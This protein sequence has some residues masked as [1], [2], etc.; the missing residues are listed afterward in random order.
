[1][2]KLKAVM[3]LLKS[4]KVK[5]RQEGL[6][7][8]KEAFSRDDAVLNI[9]EGRAWLVVYQALFTAVTSEKAEC[10]KKAASGKNASTGVAAL[11]RLGDATSAVRWLV[12]RSNCML[13][14]KVLTPLLAHLLQMMVYRGQLYTPLALNYL[15]TIKILL[16]WTPHMEHI[17]AATWINIAELAFNII[18]DDPI[19]GNFDDVTGESKDESMQA[20]VSAMYQ[21]DSDEDDDHE[22]SSSTQKRKRK[23][24]EHS[25]TPVPGTMHPTKSLKVSPRHSVSLEQV[26][27]AS[28]LALLFRSPT[29]PFLSEDVPNLSFAI[30]SR[31]TRFLERY[32]G[33]ASLH[34]DYLL[35]LQ[36]VLSHLC[37]NRT[38]DVENFAH[39]TWNQLVGLWGTKNKRM[40]E[41][42]VG[43]LRTLFPFLTIQHDIQKYTWADGVYKLWTL[44]SGEAESRRG[45]DSLSLDSLRFEIIPSATENYGRGVFVARTFRAG[46]HFDSSQALAW[47]MM[48]LQADCANKASL[49][50]KIGFMHTD[51]Y[52]T[53][54]R[55]LRVQLCSYFGR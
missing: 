35:A 8:L 29:A 37:L 14:T 41:S 11:R 5:E 30:L 23:A 12:E 13:T 3:E 39:S 4:S 2:T 36:P 33:D 51:Y 42:L 20:D 50:P 32:S 47:A 25:S 9:N 10:I 24:R 6:I 53:A 26:E 18:L 40:K 43:I 28:L 16:G 45:L 22:P 49:H 7:S 54:R 55:S 46:W 1:M 21:D 31:M 48:E 38:K 52:N 17:D 15:K 19:K 34:H 44:L 27:C